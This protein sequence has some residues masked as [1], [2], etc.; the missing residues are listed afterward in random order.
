[1]NRGF[2]LFMLNDV[3]TLD[4][5]DASE[6]LELTPQASKKT[7]KLQAKRESLLRAVNSTRLNTI[8]ER[9]AWLLNNYPKTR[10]SEPGKDKIFAAELTDRMKQTAA[11][12][13]QGNLFIDEFSA[14]DSSNNTHLQIT[15]LF[16]SS[17]GRQ[18][19]AHGERKQHKDEF[20]DYLLKKVRYS[21]A[22]KTETVGDMTVHIAL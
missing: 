8:E 20:A 14:E 11:T 17:I 2:D 13:F 22:I 10:G 18:L 5:N 21:N 19:N 12:Q 4:E 16:A 6:Q 7:V 15:D 3:T 1:V 9:V